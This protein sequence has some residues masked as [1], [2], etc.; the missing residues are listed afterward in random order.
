MMAENIMKIR[1]ILVGAIFA[2][3]FMV[4]ICSTNAFASEKQYVY[5]DADTYTDE[6]EEKISDEC[7]KY[8]EKIKIDIVVMTTNN[9]NGKSSE[10]FADDYMDEFH[11]GYEDDGRFDKSCI[12]LMFDF[13]NQ[14]IYFDTT[15][16]GI[17]YIDDDYIKT[18]YDDVY[19]DTHY[20]KDYYQGAIT[21][22]R[23]AYSE[24]E[25]N[26]DS[27]IEKKWAKF[28]GTYEEFYDKYLKTTI[29]TIFKSIP[30][31]LFGA[32]VITTIAM[33]IMVHQNKAKMTAGAANYKDMAN[34]CL[35]IS[36]D[37]Y[38]RQTVSTRRINTESSGGHGGSFHSSGGGHSHG[39]G[40]GR[41]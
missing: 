18:M 32:A 24:V 40:G 17:Y 33:L 19:D 36:N 4:I 8:S 13:D 34:S 22:I 29:F 5:D 1:K 6:Q 27:D 20:T 31:D 21:F 15:G 41:M 37:R 3:I 25:S 28:D 10:T 23:D 38:V 14:M 39:G 7:R 16:L 11:M 35:N 12:M 9:T 2:G 26:R 30:I